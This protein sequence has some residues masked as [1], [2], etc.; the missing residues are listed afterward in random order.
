VDGNGIEVTV[1]IAEYHGRELSVQAVTRTGRR[2]YFR[3]VERVA[4]EDSMTIGVPAHRVLV[5]RADGAASSAGAVSPAGA[6]SSDGTASGEPSA[7]ASSH[8][9][10]AAT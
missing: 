7:A 6:A 4:P 5:F 9:A 10:T 2:I 3:T 8:P 1:E